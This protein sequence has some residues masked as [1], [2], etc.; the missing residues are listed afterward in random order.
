MTDHNDPLPEDTVR[1]T[2]SDEQLLD[3][4]LT[5]WVAGGVDI[6][7][8]TLPKAA[9]DHIVN[10]EACT[11]TAISHIKARLTQHFEDP[12]ARHEVISV[13]RAVL[14]REHRAPKFIH[15]VRKAGE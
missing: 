6:T 13:C 15:V 10:C 3:L 7:M 14:A 11:D 12:V 8:T 9:A 2:V 5:A 1:A 4:Y